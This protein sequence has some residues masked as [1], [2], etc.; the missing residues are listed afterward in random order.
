MQK[1]NGRITIDGKDMGELR[2]LRIKLRD[3]RIRLQVGYEISETQSVP[4][5]GSCVGGLDDE[6]YTVDEASRV[7]EMNA[8]AAERR[9]RVGE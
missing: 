6:E 3:Y 8:R 4:Y 5:V 7:R 2:H 9:G 1:M